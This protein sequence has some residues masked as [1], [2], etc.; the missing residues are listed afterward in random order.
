MVVIVS[1]ETGSPASFA[2]VRVIGIR[3]ATM[4]DELGRGVLAN[5]EPGLQL[6]AVKVIGYVPV[7]HSVSVAQGRIDTL[8]ASVHAPLPTRSCCINP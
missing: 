5:L 4:T 2:H 6:L 3:R 8:R 7:V 1:D